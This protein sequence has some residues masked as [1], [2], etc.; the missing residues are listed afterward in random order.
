MIVADASALIAYLD[1]VDAHHGDAVEAFIG[2]DRFVVH[3]LTLTEVLVHP[4]SIGTEVTVANT[5]TSI[6]KVESPMPIDPIALARQR[7]AT[8]LE[9]PDCIVLATAM[10]HDASVLTFGLRLRRA[11]AARSS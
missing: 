2:V 9:L 7:V 8:G 1:G 5:L 3:P 11:D 10:W 4:A 6:G